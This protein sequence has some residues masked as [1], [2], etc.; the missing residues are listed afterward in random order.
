MVVNTAEGLV[1]AN[2]TEA[3]VCVAVLGFSRGGNKAHDDDE[4]L[5]Y[6]GGGGLGFGLAAALPLV[7]DASCRHVGSSANAYGTTVV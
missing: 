5:L 6:A 4:D 3:V 1:V 7:I 2:T